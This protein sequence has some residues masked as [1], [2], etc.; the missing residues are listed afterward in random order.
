MLTKFSY[1]FKLTLAFL[2][3]SM[4]PMALIFMYNDNKVYIA[5]KETA[6]EKLK[7]QRDAKHAEVKMYF[8]TIKKQVLTF[9]HSTMIEDATI[10]FIEEYENITVDRTTLNSKRTILK[11]YY[12]NHFGEKYNNEVGSPSNTQ[13]LMSELEDKD[14]ILQHA[15]ISN[16]SNPLGEKHK[17]LSSNIVPNYSQVHSKY[18]PSIEEYLNKFEYYDIFIIDINSGRIVYSVF[19]ELDYSTSLISGPYKGSNL[20]KV[21][22][23]A[24]KISNRE[25]VAFVDFEKYTP[26][27]EAP[28]SFIASPIWKDGKK[29]GVLAFQ[30]PV[31]AINNLMSLRSGMGKTGESYLVGTDN[32]LRS[33][34]FIDKN[35]YNLISSFRKGTQVKSKSISNALA[36]NTNVLL[37]SNYMGTNSF[38][39]FTPFSFEGVRWAILSEISEDESLEHL[40][41][42]RSDMLIFG[43][44]FS[45]LIIGVGFF[46]SNKMSNNIST[47]VEGLS[48]SSYMVQ[49]SSHKLSIVSEETKD[50]ISSQAG[51]VQQTATA[52]NEISSMLERNNHSSERALDLSN[53]TKSSAGSSLNIV[54]TMV[55][56]ILDISK[57]YDEI[58]NSV[59]QNNEDITQII[60][61]ISNISEKTE[62]IND[63]VFQTKLLSFNASVEAARAGEH[64]KGFAVVAE[65]V[66][67]LAAMSGQAADEITEMLSD[68]IEQVK[69]IA[70]ETKKKISG[71][72]N[73]GRLKIDKGN[74]VA[75]ECKNELNK[76]V[77]S[78][79]DLDQSIR[80]ITSASREQMTG[81]K[82]IKNAIHILDDMT[83]KIQDMSNITDTS[84]NDLLYQ[85]K[86]LRSSIKEL[87]SIIKSKE[88]LEQSESAS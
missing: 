2:L 60:S 85:S 36:G 25:D 40:Y 10:S 56:D 12:E 15:Y 63:I 81:V 38:S 47:I 54:D 76:I 59:E 30:M 13:Q 71:I 75:A 48:K 66:G 22:N 27:Y 79:N 7:S 31:D 16:N 9:S 1:K 67:N 45:L 8:D 52:M 84:S 49:D 53:N 4:I 17:L 86:G 55:N 19:K 70:N 72:V 80:D 50:L 44:I 78:I 73:E 69:N 61:V 33:D 51:S 62:V 74:S 26:S 87:S 35:K 68:S 23:K 24:K 5:L 29:V 39:S 37:T 58:S 57:S 88:D 28:A 41:A 20:A 14:I 18:H 65:E 82:D 6:I 43:L 42:I 77:T 11:S 64:G 34:T 83:N 32:L 21:F 3:V 46:I